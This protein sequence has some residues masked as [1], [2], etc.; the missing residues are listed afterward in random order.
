M[1]EKIKELRRKCQFYFKFGL[2]IKK[3]RK[4]NVKIY[5]C[6]GSAVHGNMGDQALGFCRI[7]FLKKCGINE[8]GIIEYTVRD[9]MRYW[10][11]ICKFHNEKDIII[12]RGG[13]C[14]GN[15]WLDG[16]EEIL[17]YIEQFKSNKII[18]FPQ[19]VFFSNTME[20]EKWLQRSKKVIKKCPQLYIGARDMCS[21]RMLKEYYP[22]SRLYVTPDTVLSYYP[23]KI[24]KKRQID[25][26][27]CLRDDKEKGKEIVAKDKIISILEK[28]NK[29][30]ISQDTEIDFNLKNL[31]ER[32]KKLFE[33]WEKF[34][35]SKL[36][37]TDRLHGMIFSTIT[38]TPCIV[39]DNIDGKV[40]HQY[41]WIKGLKYIFFVGNE[42]DF[43]QALEK[44]FALPTMKFPVDDM[45]IQ[46]KDLFEL[47]NNV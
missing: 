41:E 28:K 8:N 9:R 17:L 40:G 30:F 20:G 3:L 32:E 37:I 12:I 35:N 38:E 36:V 31:K 19:S 6:V 34:S 46:Y 13:G 5:V 4:K 26:M 47:I 7:E 1:I 23:E 25:V 24:E 29:T 27:I 21:F 45:W 11:Q 14:W 39:F 33:I 15:L 16:F 42:Q 2:K 44:A 10:P 18:V 22:A 43:V